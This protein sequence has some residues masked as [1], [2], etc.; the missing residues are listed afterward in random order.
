MGNHQKPSKNARTQKRHARFRR[1]RDRRIAYKSSG[2]HRAGPVKI[3]S[4]DGTERTEKAY[5]R[6]EMARVV[7]GGT[8]GRAAM[9][10]KLRWAVYRR[11]GGRCRY[12]R[13]ECGPEGA[14]WEIDHVT[15]VAKGGRD[16]WT[17]LVLACRGC[18]KR[19]SAA[20][21]EPIPLAEM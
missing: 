16:E 1:A 8:A 13:V 11:D 3:I 18:N 5:T 14:R 10:N 2:A 20:I 19:K 9:N 6:D 15:P 17:N 7:S 4:P 21:W 12:C